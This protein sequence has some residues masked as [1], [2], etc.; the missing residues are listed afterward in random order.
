MPKQMTKKLYTI[1]EEISNS[2]THGIGALLSIAALVLMI[3]TSAMHGNTIG[4]VTSTIFGSSLI[5]LYTMSTLY[6]AI[7][8]EKVKSIFKIF[9]HSTI[10]LL[11]SGSYTVFTLA[12]LR[13]INATKA[14]II[15]AIV[16]IIAIIGM[17]TYAIFK[18][19]FKVL[20]ILSY[21]VMGWVIVI[22]IPEI[23][24]F[25]KIHDAMNGLYLL[26]AGGIFYTIGIIFYALQKKN[27][28]Y[29][30]TIWHVFVLLGSICHFFS[31]ILYV[32]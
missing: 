15:F 19:R 29:F 20:N 14:W 1:G 8:N 21:V 6:H 3:V 27:F 7:Q 25:F 32:L 28:K 4:V 10:Y 23:T 22:A 30:H 9:D 11:I 12:A 13:E 17:F 5:I 2:I 16:W 31:A 18:N 26:V 24:E